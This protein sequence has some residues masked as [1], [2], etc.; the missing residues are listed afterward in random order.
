MTFGPFAAFG[1]KGACGDYGPTLAVDEELARRGWVDR[2]A[3]YRGV[4][5]P[6]P[7]CT[8]FRDIT[9]GSS[10]TLLV[11][12]DA[13]RPTLWQAGKAAREQAVEGGPWAGFK[14]GIVLQGA[15]PDGRTKPGRCALNCVNDREVYGFHPGGANAVLA[16]GSVRFL[17]AGMD[18][19]V[20]AGLVTRAG[21]EVVSGSDF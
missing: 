14:N 12:E 6:H 5:T 15:S 18:L 2:A 10:N 20:L 3:D 16:D 4:L 1:T 11:T 7:E 19:R 17:R 21:G 8:R 13:G 9:D